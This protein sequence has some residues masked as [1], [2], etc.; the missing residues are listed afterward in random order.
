[1]FNLW[2]E[3]GVLNEKANGYDDWHKVLRVLKNEFGEDGREPFHAFSKLSSK[4]EQNTVNTFWEAYTN[5][6]NTP[7]KF[8]TIC[9][10]VKKINASI[11]KE[12]MLMMK[13]DEED[14]E[15]EGEL[16]GNSKEMVEFCNKMFK[17]GGIKTRQGISDLVYEL[18]PKNY[19]YHKKEW[20]GWDSS[21]N[22]WKMSVIPL[23]LC[24]SK[25]LKSYLVEKVEY[26][27]KFKNEYKGATDKKF[28]IL[29]TEIEKVI[30]KFLCNP[31]E[32]EQ[33]VKGCKNLMVDDDL[34]FDM[35]KHLFG[36]NNGV[37][38]IENDEFRPYKFDDFV[39][40][41][42]GYDFEELR[43][44]RMIRDKTP[45]DVAR[46][47]SIESILK[48]VF[49]DEKVKKL[50][51]MIFGSAISG[52]CIEKFFVFNGAGGNGKGLL[53]EFM[54]SAL[55]DYFCEADI[56]LL[57]QKK[58]GGTG[59]NQELADI[60]KKRYLLYKEPGQFDGIE[61]SNMKDQTGGGNI[62]GRGLYTSKTVV[63]LH[64]T[65]VMECNKRPK[66][67]EEPTKGDIRRIVDIQFKSSFTSNADEVDES[68]FIYMADP[69]LK[70]DEWKHNHR[71]Y[72]LNML[73]DR[74]QELKRADYN[75]DNFIPKCVKDR[76]NDYLLGCY[77]IHTMFIDSY[78]RGD[79]N[80]FVTLKDIAIKIKTSES[81]FA[82]SK[83][84]KREMKNEV[85]YDFF[86]TQSPYKN[87][88]KDRHY[89]KI[90]D[91]R[92]SANNVLMG[93][94]LKPVFT[95]EDDN[96]EYVEEDENYI[97]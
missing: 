26:F 75:I 5:N 35:K 50:V 90:I 36:C 58:R 11:F 72:F 4:Y 21:K 77:D 43:E 19:I 3:E 28:T 22:T 40:M 61:N 7:V 16:T 78:V 79:D 95:G 59:P 76:S 87:C 67:K 9:D 1:M 49:P 91:V 82:L 56:T 38:D 33:V 66:L 13:R 68:N 23:N 47:K 41:S 93:W 64:N 31:V 97:Y 51:M 52:K 57:T 65:T 81:F 80:A 39:T 46:V 6:S 8:A 24:I 48:Q 18:Y 86:R 83:D 10:M 34:Q 37:Y 27:K 44:G 89:Y 94:V 96:D 25:I 85:I 53:D 63:E 15:D 20:Y 70:E 17:M 2:V 32:V 73:F 92:T 54:K 62:K 12:T 69:L 45:D 55:G 60:D 14:E 84:K 42:C 29:K 71:V 30:E 74:V 88:F